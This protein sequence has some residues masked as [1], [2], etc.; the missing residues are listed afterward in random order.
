[1]KAQQRETSHAWGSPKRQTHIISIC[2]RV[3]ICPFPN[4]GPKVAR[5]KPKQARSPW[6]KANPKLP[7]AMGQK[8]LDVVFTAKLVG[9]P[10]KKVSRPTQRAHRTESPV[11]SVTQTHPAANLERG[12]RLGE[13]AKGKARTRGSPRNLRTMLQESPPCPQHVAF[14]PLSVRITKAPLGSKSLLSKCWHSQG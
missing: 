13:L 10:K 6:P 4:I 2:A 8:Q 5:T 9:N 7:T 14:F 12:R 11:S 1:M 3:F